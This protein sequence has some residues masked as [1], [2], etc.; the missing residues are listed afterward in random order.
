MQS[1]ISA[2]SFGK[3]LWILRN[4]VD[5]FT[6]VIAEHNGS[7]AVRFEVDADVVFDGFVVQ[8][9]H[10]GRDA[11]NGNF[12][13]LKGLS[14]SSTALLMQTQPSHQFI[15]DEV[16]RRAIRVGSLNNSKAQIDATFCHQLHQITAKH[17]L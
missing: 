2:D 13:Q 5:R 3:L 12:L 17:H 9:L 11:G 6:G 10:A 8:V 16:S 7:V 15:L 4:S 1:R 14:V